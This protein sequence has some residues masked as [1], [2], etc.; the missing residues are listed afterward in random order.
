MSKY[1][2][3]EDS[4]YRLFLKEEGYGY[5]AEVTLGRGDDPSVTI[6]PVNKGCDMPRGELEAA[7]LAAKL[8]V[9]S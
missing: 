7:V 9:G 4:H 2:L 5:I 3:I 1:E 6:A 8:K